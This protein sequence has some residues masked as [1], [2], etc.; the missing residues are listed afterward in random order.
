MEQSDIHTHTERYD[1]PL[2]L[3]LYKAKSSKKNDD[4]D[5]DDDDVTI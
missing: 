1:G 4:H 3:I 2:N 5:D